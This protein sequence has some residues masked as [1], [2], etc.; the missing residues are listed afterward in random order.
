MLFCILIICLLDIVLRMQGEILS[1][2]LMGVKV[3]KHLIYLLSVSSPAYFLCLVHNSN[4]T[5]LITRHLYEVAV[6]SFIQ[7]PEKKSKSETYYS[8]HIVILL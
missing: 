3:L 5:L 8:Y 4:P 6:L 1:W 2:L 7:I